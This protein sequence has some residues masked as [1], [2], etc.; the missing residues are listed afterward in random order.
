[1]LQIHLPP[2]EVYKT[3]V[4]MAEKRPDLKIVNQNPGRYFIEVQK[5][6][7][8]LSA[9]ATELSEGQTL[10]FIWAD[11]GETNQTGQELTHSAAEDICK[12]LAVK[13]IV[14]DK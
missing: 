8:S 14:K 11:A 10:L 12:E 13:C 2:G 7:Q 5:N 9:Q 3:M 1:M 4:K 6:G